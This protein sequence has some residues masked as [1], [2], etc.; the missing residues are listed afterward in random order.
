MLWNIKELS[1]AERS[2]KP[3]GIV[4][5]PLIHD[6]LSAVNAV[7]GLTTIAIIIR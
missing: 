6:V 3:L 2:L 5:K 7:R 1:I 4:K